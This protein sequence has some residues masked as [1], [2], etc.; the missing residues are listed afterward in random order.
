MNRKSSQ[1]SWRSWPLSVK[2]TVAITSLVILV[3]I[4]ITLISIRREQQSFQQELE[5]QAELVLAI[6]VSAASDPLYTLDTDNLSDIMEA[7]GY[8]ALDKDLQILA[9]GRAYDST[10]RII[11]DAYDSAAVFNLEPD[12]FGQQLIDSETTIFEWQTDQLVAGR[13]V[14][15]GDLRLG[16]VSI[17]LS[18]AS[19]QS[20]LA[21][22]R[23]QGLMVALMMTILSIII[24]IVLSRSITGPLQKLMTATQLISQGD[25]TKPIS[26]NSRDELAVL[27][28]GMEQMRADLSKLYAGLEDQVSARTAELAQ[29]EERFRRVVSS[30]SDYIYATEITPD[31]THTNL[32]VS[33]KVVDLTGYS[34]EQL[35]TDG[36]FWLS[37]IIHPEDHFLAQA[38]MNRLAE[39]QDSTAEYRL[40]KANKEVIWVRNSGRVERDPESENIVVYAVVSDVT[41]QK[42]DEVALKIARDQALEAS[43]LKSELLARV[44]HELRTPLGAVLGFSEMLN[45]EMAGSLTD[46]QKE[47]TRKIITNSE[48]LTVMVNE[49]LDQARLEAGM[50]SLNRVEFS[51]ANLLEQTRLVAEVLAQNKGLKLRTELTE[52]VP[53]TLVGDDQRLRQILTNLT[54]NAIKF[55][56]HGSVQ[57]RIFCPGEYQW[58][59]EVSDTGP[60]IPEEAQSL[61]FDPFR[62]VD[63]S[64]T[65][66]HGGSGLGLSITKKLTELMGGVILLKSNEVGGAIFTVI[67]PINLELETA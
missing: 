46:R 20:K 56:E 58:A 65:R 49:L 28:T 61:I 11:A 35:M 36:D 41:A 44:S 59:I 47:M 50:V 8:Q 19:L 27:A 18:T 51:P 53:A 3:I 63:G 26:V 9:S 15:I 34:A 10:G 42:E 24:A 62:Q 5:R 13:S 2:L 39:G 48:N 4:S 22:V 43:R 52:D 6:M 57:V 32:F 38:S 37:T 23:N 40:V 30:I 29:S 12:A 7:V 64:V 16:A 14:E 54:G 33:P 31:G 67:L 17:G 45:L 60:G 66:Q 25:L 21:A 1:L 55:T